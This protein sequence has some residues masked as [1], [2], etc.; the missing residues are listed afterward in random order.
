[1]DM[2]SQTVAGYQKMKT[3]YIYFKIMFYFLEKT[4]IKKK[5]FDFP[6]NLTVILS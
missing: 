1:M 5:L 4:P 2:K 6:L 3:T